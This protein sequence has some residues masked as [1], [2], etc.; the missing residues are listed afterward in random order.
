MTA[1]STD[2]MLIKR[3]AGRRLYDPQAACCVT[4]DDIA[5][6]VRPGQSVTIVDAGSGQDITRAVLADIS[7]ARQ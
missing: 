6:S 3:H 1:G 2:T 5:A 7:A 4:V